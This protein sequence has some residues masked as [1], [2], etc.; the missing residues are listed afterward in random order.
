MVR[1]VQD[2]L[3][4]FLKILSAHFWKGKHTTQEKNVRVNDINFC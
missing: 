1:R 4:E 3:Q 2:S